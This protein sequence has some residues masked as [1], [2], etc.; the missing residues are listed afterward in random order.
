MHAA[1]DAGALG[2]DEPFAYCPHITLAQEIPHQRL[3]EVRRLAQRRWSEYRGSR[4]F[5]VK[6]A[7]FVQNTLSD[8]WI[9]LAEFSLGAVAAR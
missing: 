1:M 5:L 9:D 6:Q 3:P 4:S 8:A 2:F 7:M